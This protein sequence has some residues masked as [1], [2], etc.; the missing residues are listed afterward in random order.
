[1]RDSSLTSS[2]L[3]VISLSNSTRI[4]FDTFEGIPQIRIIHGDD[5]IVDEELSR[6]EVNQI[7]RWTELAYARGQER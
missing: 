3:I 2:N 5:T 4:E 7:R 1:M 6:D